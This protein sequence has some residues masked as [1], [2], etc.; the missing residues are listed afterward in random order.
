MKRTLLFFALCAGLWL[1]AAD[2]YAQ[3]ETEYFHIVTTVC[4]DAAT[5]VTVNYHSWNNNSC[6]LYTVYEDTDFKDAK[7]VAPVCERWSSKGIQNTAETSTFYTKERYVCHATLSGLEP[8]TRYRFKIVTDG[9]SKKKT[10]RESDVR[11]FRTAGQK[12]SWNF[13]AF[14]DFQHRENPVTLPLIEM[15]KEMA[16]TPDL[17][18]CSGDMVDVA[19][20]EYEW[21]YLLDNETFKDFVYAASPGDHA[22][23]ACD[24]VNGGYPQYDQPHTFNHLFHFPQN[25][26]AT[27]LNSS[28][29]FYYNNVLFVALDMNNSDVAAGPRFDEEVQWFETTLNR[30]QGTYQYLVVF[31]HKSVFG[32]EIVD[33]V[34]A[35]KLRP[36]WFPVFQ[37][38]KVDLV[39]SGHDHIYS[40]TYALDGDQPAEDPAKG[41]YYLDMGSSG[42][43]RRPLDPSLTDSPRHAKV[44]NLKETGQSCACNIEV[45]DNRMKV[46]VYDQ[47]RH[48][49]DGFTIPAKRQLHPALPEGST[50]PVQGLAIEA[51]KPANLD[52]FLAFIE[53]ELV[54]A[55]FNLL[56]L[57]VDWN[58]AFETHPE[59]RDPDPLT[60]AD[61]QRMVALC[62][63]HG[64]RLV[65]QINLLGH[66]SWATTTYALL[67][68]YPQFDETP[69]V[70]TEN[71]GP[72][73]NADSLYCKSYCPLHPEVHDVVF[74]VVDE[75]CDAFESDA[76]HAGMDEVF[77]IGMDECPR[78]KGHDRSELFAGEVTLIRNHL[79]EKG[80]QLMIWGDRLL[81]G[82]TT[83]LGEWEASGNDTWRAIDLIPKDVFI[84]DWHYERADLT[85]VYFATKGLNVASCGYR[86]TALCLQQIND[87]ARFRAQSSPETA[88]R[89]QGYIHTIWSGND[90]FLRR[91][92]ALKSGQPDARGQRRGGGDDAR[93]L[94][95]VI[96]A[97]A[98]RPVY[99]DK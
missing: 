23:W 33:E 43:K 72:W 7:K 90:F 22:Y 1:G 25:G 59:L 81:D 8:D 92:Y 17:M 99:L 24:K 26:A 56:I 30:L 95:A 42:D 46:T 79:A 64:I 2:A 16:G 27:S 50:L 13:V 21:T 66:Q 29:Y 51:P 5:A 86:N 14:T 47:D 80:R 84:C 85:P 58:Y 48:V 9:K 18:L 94:R 77:Y 73:P 15:M 62:R 96:Q 69:S 20:N 89:L 74:A 19:G 55:H 54:P 63:K 28:Y 65:P 6:V 93:A 40:R 87:I 83:G 36:Q 38:Y 39:L 76:F 78:C 75:L 67:R 11:T 45:D 31:E 41:T 68:E 97:F 91:Y 53:E 98:G 34:V 4:E 37:K 71:Y 57:R 88:G 70:K 82:K 44:M 52:R 35:K 60:K 12:G 61:V 3:P 49:V 10:A 32:S